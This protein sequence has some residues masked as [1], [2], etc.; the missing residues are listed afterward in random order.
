MNAPTPANTTP[1][2]IATASVPTI[3]PSNVPKIA[4][5]NTEPS[6]SP[7]RSGVVIA[8]TQVSPPAQMQPHAAP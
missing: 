5:P 8:T 7:R 4:E 3:G 1:V 6:T 2:P